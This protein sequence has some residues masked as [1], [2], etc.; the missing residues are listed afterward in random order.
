MSTTTT[1]ASDAVEIDIRLQLAALPGR[2]RHLTPALPGVTSALHDELL[3]TMRDFDTT[4][5]TIDADDNLTPS[6]K[7]HALAEA[8]Q[9]AEAALSAFEQ[10]HVQP[11]A[12]RR[13]ALEQRLRQPP[14]APTDP[15]DRQI[16]EARRAEIR[17]GLRDLDAVERD[18][19]YFAATNPDLIDAM[20]SA[21][22]VLHRERPGALPTLRPMVS[23]EH[24]EARRLARAAKAS[25]EQAA[26]ARELKTLETVLGSSVA[27]ARTALARVT[28]R[29]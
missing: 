27:T 25:P 26:E 15:A 9:R 13:D 18:A 24:V 17:A 23:P 12:N 4:A 3:A 11:L 2:L 28:S 20:E 6:G 5:A 19:V 21:P 7:A 1:R 29:V 8:R 10:R 16:L 22:P 14:P